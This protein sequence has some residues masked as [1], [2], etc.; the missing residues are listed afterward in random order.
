MNRGGSLFMTSTAN[1]GVQAAATLDSAMTTMDRHRCAAGTSD[2]IVFWS[3][4]ESRSARIKTRARPFETIPMSCATQ[5]H[6][7][8]VIQ[9]EAKALTHYQ[10]GR[11]LSDRSPRAADYIAHDKRRKCPSQLG[12]EGLS[13]YLEPKSINLPMGD[14]VQTAY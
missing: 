7:M 10:R 2:A 13:A 14:A 6:V 4:S 8:P 1:R 11:D 9:S 5:R 12:P 3:P